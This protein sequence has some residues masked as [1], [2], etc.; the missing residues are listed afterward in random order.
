MRCV[1]FRLCATFGL[2][3][4]TKPNIRDPISLEWNYIYSWGLYCKGGRTQPLD[5]SHGKSAEHFIVCILPFVR[6]GK[7]PTKL[8]H[9]R[10]T[11][12]AQRRSQLKLTCK[13]IRTT[14]GS[15]R[16]ISR[17][18][19]IAGI[20]WIILGAPSASQGSRFGLQLEIPM[21]YHWMPWKRFKVNWSRMKEF[22]EL[23]IVSAKLKIQKVNFGWNSIKFFIVS[24]SS[25][26]RLYLQTYCYTR[27][28]KLLVSLPCQLFSW[29]SASNANNLCTNWQVFE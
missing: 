25:L 4:P 5:S 17:M 22:V 8:V 18:V 13:F 9:R 26:S 6:N 27:R 24:L 3:Q 16:S 7:N 11:G 2:H 15:I 1:S 23:H 10:Q 19:Y 28:N 12:V 20:V 21:T 29:R 14:F